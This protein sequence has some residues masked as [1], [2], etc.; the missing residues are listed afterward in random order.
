M[1]VP[2]PPVVE[3][4]VV[5]GVV[6]ES[7]VVGV[8]VDAVVASVPLLVLVL[9]VAVASVLGS[10]VASVS[11]PPGLKQAPCSRKAPTA[12]DRGWIDITVH[13]AAG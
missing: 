8:V 9:A 7:L 13:L 11:C 3:S 1:Q 10:P 4:V 6:V 5:V 12:K 2:Q